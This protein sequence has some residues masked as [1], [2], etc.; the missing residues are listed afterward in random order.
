MKINN[1]VRKSGHYKRLWEAA[2]TWVVNLA[3]DKTESDVFG[4]SYLSSSTLAIFCQPDNLNAIV[5]TECKV[6]FVLV[7]S[8]ALKLCSGFIEAFSQ[9]L[10]EIS[11]CLEILSSMN[12][13]VL[14]RH[15]RRIWRYTSSYNNNFWT[16]ITRVC[17]FMGL[18]QEVIIYISYW[19]FVLLWFPCVSLRYYR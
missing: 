2:V 10:I 8:S 6:A 15:V 14:R 18:K 19:T 4:T 7:F 1:G 5:T 13:N 11:C 9:K 3:V 16:I 17:L 12:N